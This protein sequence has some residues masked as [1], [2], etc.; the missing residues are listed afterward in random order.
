[1]IV[2]SLLIVGC[3]LAVSVAAGIGDRKC[4]FSLLRLTGVPVQLLHRIV[5]LAAAVPLIVISVL[6]AGIG[7]V[8]AGLFLHSE[9]G[10]TLQVPGIGYYAIV[11]ALAASLAVIAATPLPI[12]ERVTGPEVARNE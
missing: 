3:S 12:I 4:P 5:A 11:L 10:V 8:A 1:M 9:L 2:A 6:S 7:L